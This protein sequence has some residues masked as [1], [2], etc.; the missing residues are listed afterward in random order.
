M[1]KPDDN[2]A[3]S[4]TETHDEGTPFFPL[5]FM[6]ECMVVFGIIIV[7]FGLSTFLPAGLEEE[8]NPF[9]TPAHIKPEWYF[10]SVYQILKYV[11]QGNFINGITFLNLSILSQIG[12]FIL[13][14]LVPFLDFY[15]YKRP[16][17]RPIFTIIGILVILV[18]IVF[19]YL[20]WFSGGKEPIFH[21]YIR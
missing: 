11:P 20:G 3:K 1:E 14:I 19:T 15:K 13:L 9:S 21:T 7:L 4:E 6:K 12:A 2:L 18:T 8:A 16:Q 10:L 5:H 17:R